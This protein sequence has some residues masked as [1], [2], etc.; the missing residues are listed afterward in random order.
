MGVKGLKTHVLILQMHSHGQCGA[1]DLIHVST[2]LTYRNLEPGNYTEIF[3]IEAC[4]PVTVVIFLST[5]TIFSRIISNDW[6][7][8]QTCAFECKCTMT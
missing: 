7:N 8:Y 6:Q 3:A 2:H 4:H 5:S 1:C